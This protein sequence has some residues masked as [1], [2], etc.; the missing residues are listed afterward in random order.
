MNSLNAAGVK[1]FPV[2]PPKLS[3]EQYLQLDNFNLFVVIGNKE[4]VHI[5]MAD[6]IER[7]H[8]N[9]CPNSIIECVRTANT[10]AE[11]FSDSINFDLCVKLKGGVYVSINEFFPWLDAFI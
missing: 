11:S 7:Y 6:A 10:I 2:E 4:P 3:Q 9:D 1:N 8:E 5:P